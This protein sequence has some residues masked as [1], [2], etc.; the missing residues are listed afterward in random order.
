MKLPAGRKIELY[1]HRVRTL[2]GELEVAKKALWVEG[3]IGGSKKERKRARAGLKQ[4][5]EAKPL[6]ISPN[7]MGTIRSHE[8]S[9]NSL[10]KLTDDDF[11][12]AFIFK[13]PAG[14]P[15]ADETHEDEVFIS[16]ECWVTVEKMISCDLAIKA[17]LPVHRHYMIIAVGA[18]YKVCDDEAQSNRILSAPARGG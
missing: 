2:S 8:R 6:S 10:H 9:G 17:V 4:L 14:T 11:V 1:D 16:H 12:Y 7:T 15:R 18:D 3:K 5:A 13:M